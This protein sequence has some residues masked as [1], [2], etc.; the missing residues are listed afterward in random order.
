MEKVEKEVE[1]K[2][3]K[4]KEQERG[5]LD[6]K[7]VCFGRRQLNFYLRVVDSGKS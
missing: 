1:E 7:A 6:I 5:L 2:H 4:E 3:E